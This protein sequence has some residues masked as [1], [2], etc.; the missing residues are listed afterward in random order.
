M[1]KGFNPP[2]YEIF[3]HYW[4]KFFGIS[5]YSVRFPSLI[6]NCISVFFV[7]KITKFF[8]IKIA[9]IAT[10]IFIF[11]NFHI[12]FSHNARVYEMAFL[13]S[14]ILFYSLLKISK[15]SSTTLYVF[16]AILS[17]ILLLYSHYIPSIQA[18]LFWITLII[19]T[20]KNRLLLSLS[21]LP[22]LSIGLYILKFKILY[23]PVSNSEE[24]SNSVFV[25][26]Y[27]LLVI[28][29]NQPVVLI[30]SL[31]IL[32]IN[33]ILFQSSKNFIKSSF[34]YAVFFSQLILFSLLSI[35]IFSIQFDFFN[36]RYQ[37]VLSVFFYIA[38]ASSFF[39]STFY[40]KKWIL[41]TILLCSFLVTVNLKQNS[42]RKYKE[43]C[44]FLTENK[45]KKTIVAYSPDWKNLNLL[46]Y[47]DFNLFKK[48]DYTKHFDTITKQLSE[49]NIYFIDNVPVSKLDDF[50]EILF[51]QG[52]EK[53]KN[54]S[55]LFNDSAK[56]EIKSIKNFDKTGNVIIYYKKNN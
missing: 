24:I 44:H 48:K 30:I 17:S 33:I 49:K 27:N 6:F 51:F 21:L 31:S 37:I 25:K 38:I 56:W 36:S 13:W 5:V 35:G 3:L 39:Y 29:S 15:K 1:F 53:I 45:S 54:P 47:M 42:T 8:N 19:F 20:K 9:F 52:D 32:F 18:F 22:F 10:L 40:I 34:F 50:N 2:L 28:F 11:S 43:V 41:A 14:L 23:L 46:Y 4:T 12:E 16:T 26:I 7:F 55:F